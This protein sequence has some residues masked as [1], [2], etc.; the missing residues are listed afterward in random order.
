MWSATRQDALLPSSP[1][2]RLGSVVHRLLEEAGCGSV[3][4]E[5]SAID[6]RWR[7]LIAEAESEMTCLH[8]ERRFV[9]LSQHVPQFDVIRIRAQARTAE[10]ARYVRDAETRACEVTDSPYGTELRV[11]SS[12]GLIEGRIDRVVRTSTGP[13]IQDYKSGAIFSLRDGVDHEIR[14]EYSA[15]LRLYAALYYEAVG[16]WPKRL[17]LV[18]LSG[19]PQ[20]VSYSRA[21]SLKLL[22]SARSVLR[23]VNDELARSSDDWEAVERALA[24]PSPSACRFCTYRPACSTY[25]SHEGDSNENWPADTWGTF[26]GLAS[27]GNGR[28]LL[29][30]KGEGV[31]MSYVRGI[32]PELAAATGLASVRE[33]A[34]IG[35]FS[36]R[37][38]R[39]PRAYEEAP[40]TWVH[41]VNAPRSNWR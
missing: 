21:D 41:S 7:E 30:L 25:L 11:Q 29:S 19:S 28:L 32:S 16:D 10:L 22:E 35:V 27:L 3:P 6:S 12:D 34:W 40:L 33:G 5:G 31:A 14:P 36:T 2:A 23:E 8:L 37:R 26:H 15:Q 38:T 9:P 20:E 4:A 17:E 13:V 1:A 24:T 39:S 18:P